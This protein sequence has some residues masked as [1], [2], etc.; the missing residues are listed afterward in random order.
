MKTIS[1]LPE[2]EFHPTIDEFIE[3]YYSRNLIYLASDLIHRGVRPGSIVSAIRISIEMAGEGGIHP[4]KHF[5]PVYS[6][7]RGIIYRDCKLSPIGWN[8]VLLNLPAG[9]P[10]AARI[11]LELCELLQR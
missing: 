7:S 5:K 1:L 9:D 4:S 8:L 3:Q 2:K 11:K 6:S 10:A